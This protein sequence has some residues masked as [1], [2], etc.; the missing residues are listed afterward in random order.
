MDNTSDKES[1]DN[2]KPNK[3]STKLTRNP[4]I[5]NNKANSSKKEDGNITKML[6]G[7]TSLKIQK[8]LRKLSVKKK[9]LNGTKVVQQAKSNMN[10]LDL[11]A[12]SFSDKEKDIN[13]GAQLSFDIL[14]RKKSIK[15]NSIK[16]KKL[17]KQN[18][19]NL[20]NVDIDEKGHSSD[21]SSCLSDVSAKYEN[22]NRNNLPTSSKDLVDVASTEA[23][24]LALKFLVKHNFPFYGISSSKLITIFSENSAELEKNIY[25]NQVL[26]A[27]CNRYLQPNTQITSEH[28]RYAVK[29]PHIYKMV[30][31]A[32]FHM[33]KLRQ[34][35]LF[36]LSGISGSGKSKTENDIISSLS[37]LA[38]G[39]NKV[40]TKHIM[41]ADSI[42]AVL[43]AFC[44]AATKESYS[45]TRCVLW[46]E[47]QFSKK[48]RVVGHKTLVF[49]LDRWRTTEPPINERNFNVFY[50]LIYGADHSVLNRLLLTPDEENYNYLRSEKIE[51]STIPNTFLAISKPVCVAMYENLVTSMERCKISA[52]IIHCIFQVLGAVLHLGNCEFVDLIGVSEAATSK[53]RNELVVAAKLIG[54]LPRY[55]ENILTCK[56]TMIGDD[57]C[58]VYMNSYGASRQRDE[59]ARLLYHLVVVWLINSM[60][61]KLST[62]KTFNQLAILN[63]YGFQTFPNTIIGSNKNSS[64]KFLSTFDQFMINM[65]NEQ[66]QSYVT[67][68][69]LGNKLTIDTKMSADS[70]P[71]K[72]I[73]YKARLNA[74]RLLS[75]ANNTASSGMVTT[76]E[77]HTQYKDDPN[78]DIILLNALSDKHNSDYNFISST[79]RIK[80]N[81]QLLFGINHYFFPQS[82]IADGFAKHNNDQLI[83]T[84]FVSLFQ[85]SSKNVFLQKLFESDFVK[86]YLHPNNKSTVLEAHIT[87]NGFELPTVQI[88]DE[89]NFPEANKDIYKRKN[90]Y[91]TTEIE[92]IDKAAPPITQIGEMCSAIKNICVAADTYNQWHVFH[93]RPKNPAVA[94][95][96]GSFDIDFVKK[97][98]QS[99][100]IPEISSKYS[101][102]EYT[103]YFLKPDF[104]ERFRSAIDFSL[105]KF[106]ESDIEAFLAA[107]KLSR[108]SDY[109]LGK[110]YIFLTEDAWQTLQIKIKSN[111][112]FKSKLFE[113]RPPNELE[114]FGNIFK[115]KSSE[116][117]NKKS[118]IG[119]DSLGL[120][121]SNQNHSADKISGNVSVVSNNIEYVSSES[122]YDSN[123]ELQALL[124]PTNGDYQDDSDYS[125]NSEQKDSIDILLDNMGNN[126]SHNLNIDFY[127]NISDWD[128]EKSLNTHDH[129][130]EIPMSRVRVFWERVSIILT[131]WIPSSLLRLCK[132]K[133]PDIQMAWREKVAICIL[134]VNLWLLLLFFIVGLGL[135]MCPKQY[136]YGLD[137]ISIHNTPDDAYVALRGVAYDV[138]NFLSVPHGLSRG[139]ATLDEM[140]MY[141]GK[142]INATFPIPLRSACPGLIDEKDDPY[143]LMFTKID[144]EATGEFPFI[145]TPGLKLG[146]E[147]SDTEFY[148]NYA[149]PKLKL[150]RKGNIVWD[151][152]YIKEMHIKEGKYMRVLD[153]KVFDLSSYFQTKDAPENISSKKWSYL[154]PYIESI[155]NDGG[156]RSTDISEYWLKIPLPNA[157]IE[158]NLNCMMNLFYVGQ[159]DTRKSFRCLFPNYLLLSFACVLMSVIVIKFLASLQ[160]SP[161]KKPQ[162]SDK[163]VICQ[164]P[165]YTEGED[166]L[167]KTIDG[168]AGLNYDDKQKLMFIICDGNIVGSG[169][170]RS[171][172]R[173]VLDILGCDSKIDPP[174]LS[175]ISLGEGSKQHNIAK[176]YCGL[177]NYEG[178]SVPYIVVAKTGKPSE[179][180]RPGNRG[181]RDSQM[182]LLHFLNRSHFDLP[183]TPLDLEI[184]HTMKNVIGVHPNLYEFILM[185]DADTEV[186]PESLNSLVSSMIHDSKVVGICG[187]TRI[188][189]EDYSWTTMIQVYEYFISHHMAKAFESIFGSV[190]CLPG[191]FSMYRI[192]SVNGKPIIASKELVKDYSENIVDTLHKKNLLSL[193]EDRYLTTLIM[194]HFPQYK[195]KFTSDARCK[196]TVPDTWSVLLSQRRRWI[197]STVHN[198]VELMFLPKLCG[199]CFFSMRFVVFIDLFGTLTMPCTVMYLL[200]LAYLGISKTSQV[201]Y[202]SLILIGAIYGLQAV[203]FIIK[204]QWQHI[205]WMLIYILAYP[206]WSLYIPIYSFW[207]FDDFSWGNTRIVIGEGGKRKMIVTEDEKFNLADIPMKTWSEYEDVLIEKHQQIHNMG[208]MMRDIEM[209]LFALSNKAPNVP[210]SIHSAAINTISVGESRSLTPALNNTYSHHQINHNYP[211]Y[212]NSAYYND[213]KVNQI[214]NY[215]R[216]NSGYY[217]NEL[218]ITPSPIQQINY[219]PQINYQNTLNNISDQALAW[220][221]MPN[222]NNNY[223]NSIQ[224]QKFI[225]ANSNYNNNNIYDLA[226]QP[227]NIPTFPSD[228]QIKLE[229]IKILSHSDLHALTKKQLVLHLEQTFCVNLSA[230]KILIG[231][232]VK[233]ILYKSQ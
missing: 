175:F 122:D 143:W 94:S 108:D 5:V 25:S 191:C 37:Y 69:I 116:K 223:L 96:K 134:I 209:E 165:C 88:P 49:G 44:H 112:T 27:F 52:Q 18:D 7:Y 157:D 79:T 152:K 228:E 48:G 123:I 164:V 202:I 174:G 229:I 154:S 186:E 101:P 182:I 196:T 210:E 71:S 97:Q 8:S 87:S 168:L 102:V 146:T 198:L 57:L 130:E 212:I 218:R 11:N 227:Q 200:Y 160:L 77:S 92:N 103:V 187:E 188:S 76:L 82:Y 230:K 109:L 181:K 132:I 15:R 161:R 36:I 231:E 42:T 121:F 13:L 204:R 183:M 115:N 205:G 117:K 151:Y 46:R 162:Q 21:V 195:T 144:P 91:L 233:E 19:G 153:G 89:E 86:M 68:A 178:H 20:D 75:G 213:S 100:A 23:L 83:S 149:L 222:S 3:Y 54:V 2:K 216:Q 199:F 34:N 150:Y 127:D 35:Q 110:E 6:E 113:K 106:D 137:E 193:G 55:L 70:L 155:F 208:L 118:S 73:P 185:V 45:S 9:R 131:F 141:A 139:G 24:S 120:N 111:G 28:A 173:I 207:H 47:M 67:E 61:N 64:V 119:F 184:Y 124:K 26:E 10:N 125:T 31:D 169:N 63:M 66:L 159:V 136:V 85:Q 98:I 4:S 104:V 133:H 129:V 114:P 172:P 201:G 138:T 177:Y 53:N 99:Y 217:Q 135:I 192:K 72:N 16:K 179:K 156:T 148:F 203:I 93:I 81:T 62:K 206:L 126:N 78:S 84:D 226:F 215:D 167:K 176:L 140:M 145:H 95:G 219:S 14:N 107:I 142:D 158:R 33:R 29:R 90:N 170:D 180:S 60:N 59:L 80:K 220:N 194:K 190:T 1:S 74:S 30:T 65:A 39:G 221:N 38:S 171:T 189:N 41:Q 128:I 197:N 224:H 22:I 147:L 211:A 163:F 105:K 214:Q 225:S 50:Y 166:S 56:T 32:Y 40:V 12:Y 51:E 43:E 232:I 58:T 17:K